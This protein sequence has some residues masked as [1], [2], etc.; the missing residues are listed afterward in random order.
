MEVH[1]YSEKKNFSIEGYIIS[2]T[3]VFLYYLE[4]KSEFFLFISE[5]KTKNNEG[6]QYLGI[7]Y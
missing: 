7:G 3:L 5:V 2:D 4:K 6:F 1:I